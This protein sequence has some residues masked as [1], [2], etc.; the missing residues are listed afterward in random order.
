MAVKVKNVLNA[1]Q[2]RVHDNSTQ[3]RG[4]MLSWFMDIVELLAIERS[5]YCLI[6]STPVATTDGVLA[7]INNYEQILSITDD[8]TYFLDTGDRLTLEEAF[9]VNAKGG[10]TPVGFTELDGVITLAPVPG[11]GQVSVTYKRGQ[12]VYLDDDIDT[13]WPSNFKPLFVRT[14]LT[15]FYEFDTDQRLIGSVALDSTIINILKRWDNQFQPMPKM[16][17]YLR[18]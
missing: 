6:K 11:D 3:T 1:V 14:I 5:W 8:S 2:A 12:Q 10:S 4:R 15:A 13:I 16:S 9:K 17:K 18:K 7:T